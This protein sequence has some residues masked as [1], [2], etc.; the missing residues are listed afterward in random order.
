MSLE[1]EHLLQPISDQSPC[2]E[3]LSFSN[4]FHEIKKAKTQDD[5][6]LEQGDWVAE[7]KQADWS[8]VA[9]KSIELLSTK[10]K[11]IRL[12]TWL[13]EAWS[14]LY[15]F[16]GIAKS[17]ELTHTISNMYWNDIH[18]E[19]HDNDLDQRLGLF[20][21]LVNQVPSLLKKIPLVNVQPLYSL[22][23]YE[24]MLHQLN[25][26]RKHSDDSEEPSRAELE[27]FEQALH[28]TP[29]RFQL[30]NYENFKLVLQHWD[31]T[32]KVLDELMQ[33]DAPSFAQVDS[34]LEDIHKSLK[35]IYKT[36]LIDQTPTPA[37]VTNN[38]DTTSETSAPIIAP[39]AVANMNTQN[40][41]SFNPVHQNHI[42]NREQAMKVLQQIADYFET[43]EPHSP[44]SYMLQKTIKWSKMPLHEWLT[45]VIKSENPLENVQELLGVKQDST[46]SDSW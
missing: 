43:N 44:V 18:P 21:G 46:E 42:Q 41:Q 4:E 34:Q 27:Q 1:I 30:E 14:N 37:P 13:T 38:L 11:D 39:N 12:L 24:N 5:P 20:Q 45:Q 26:Q 33:L 29:R 31:N 17:L 7:P 28:S 9:S 22:F 19:I 32:K 6:F 23:D 40:Q 16:E 35:K 36:D 15:G 3:D 10:S 25:N 2:G 8:F